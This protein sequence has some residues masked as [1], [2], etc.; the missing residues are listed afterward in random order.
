MMLG[1]LHIGSFPIDAA[2]E[3]CCCAC[4]GAM[5]AQEQQKPLTSL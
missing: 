4:R 1:K 5:P 2:V 3:Q